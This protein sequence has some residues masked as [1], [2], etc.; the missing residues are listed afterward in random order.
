MMSAKYA[1]GFPGKKNK[2]G[3]EIYEEI[4]KICWQR[5]L[6]GFNLDKTNF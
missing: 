6:D 3:T 5:A 1:S 2:P 4:E